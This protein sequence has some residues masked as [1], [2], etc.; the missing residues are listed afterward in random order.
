MVEPRRK[1]VSVETILVVLVCFGWI[2]VVVIAVA[3]G[4]RLAL[5]TGG[6]SEPLNAAAI[7]DVGVAASAHLASPSGSTPAPLAWTSA[8]P[9]QTP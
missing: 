5:A 6:S 8:N 4:R 2:P 9:D 3:R 7:A 1:L